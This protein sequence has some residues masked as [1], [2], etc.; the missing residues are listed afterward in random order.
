ML[1]NK[2]KYNGK[3]L[4]HQEFS[5]MEVGWKI[6]TFGAKMQDPQLGVWH[7]IDP[8]L[9]K[10]RCEGSRLTIMPLIIR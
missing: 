4:Q 8:L 9:A 3:E 1:Q 7:N 6:M 2:Y 5:V 10:S